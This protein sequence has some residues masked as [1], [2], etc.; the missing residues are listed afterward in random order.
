MAWHKFLRL[1]M[2]RSVLPDKQINTII[3]SKGADER[4][5]CE[6]Y[7]C[8][9]IKGGSKCQREAPVRKRKLFLWSF[10]VPA[11]LCLFPF[12]LFVFLRIILS[13]CTSQIALTF[14]GLSFSKVGFLDST[15]LEKAEKSEKK[16]RRK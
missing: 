3:K 12:V 1:D 15:R 6:F 5:D 4:S 13:S 14:L 9:R 8:R 7:K 11:Q 16:V 10:I 2:G